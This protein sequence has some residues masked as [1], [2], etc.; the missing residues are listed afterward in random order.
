MNWYLV[1]LIFQGIGDEQAFSQRQKE[2]WRLIRAD[3]MAWA[4][5]KATVLGWL[6]QQGTD[7]ITTHRYQKFLGVMEILQIPTLEDGAHLHHSI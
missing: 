7:E 1:K 6:E 4:F 3:E 5:E 2:Q